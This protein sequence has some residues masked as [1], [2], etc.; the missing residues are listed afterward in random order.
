[1]AW[2]WGSIFGEIKDS[3][4]NIRM[5]KLEEELVR[6]N[7]GVEADYSRLPTT[8]PVKT[9]KLWND[10]GTLKVSAGPPP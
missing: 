4:L 10:G 7:R 8:D 1:M 2:H 3:V 6:M 5:K 9:G